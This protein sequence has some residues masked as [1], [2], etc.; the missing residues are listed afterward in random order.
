MY[1]MN[2]KFNCIENHLIHSD[3]EL[4]KLL[5]NYFENYLNN[6]TTHVLLYDYILQI[7]YFNKEL[8]NGNKIYN[9]IKTQKEKYYTNLKTTIR[10]EIKKNIF[11]MVKLIDYINEIKIKTDS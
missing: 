2:D 7:K 3:D 9:I 1:K 8:I 4:L 6:D 10:L 11:T 5:E